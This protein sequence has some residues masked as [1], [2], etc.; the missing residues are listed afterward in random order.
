MRNKR[1]YSQL[2]D[3]PRKSDGDFWSSSSYVEFDG[4]DCFGDKDSHRVAEQE[5]RVE[6][7]IRRVSLLLGDSHR[8]ICRGTRPVSA[9]EKYMNAWE[10]GLYLNVQDS[11]IGNWRRSGRL[12]GVKDVRLK[13]YWFAVSELDKVAFR[14]KGIA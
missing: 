9:K 11:A 10:A 1:E 8:K 13:V 5:R 14:R 2:M 7:H 6:S 3:R 4:E 12:P